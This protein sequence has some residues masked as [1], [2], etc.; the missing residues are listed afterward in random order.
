MIGEYNMF[1]EYIYDTPLEI[2]ADQWLEML[3]NDEI[4][5]AQDR[6][7]IYAVLQYDGQPHATPIAKAIGLKGRGAINLQVDRLGKR[8][9]KHL[10]EI[11]FPKQEDGNDR[12]W[13]IPYLG[14]WQPDKSRF[15][16]TLRPALKEAAEIYFA[17]E[18]KE[19]K[20]QPSERLYSKIEKQLFASSYIDISYQRYLNFK[21]NEL[22][23]ESY[24][25]EILSRLNELLKG[26]EI[27]DRTV[28]DIVKK[29]QKENPSAGSFVHWSNTSDLVKYA[30]AKP[31]EV[32]ILLS[33]LYNSEALISDRIEKFREKAKAFNPDISLGAP[34]FG[35]LLAAKDYK[36]YPIYK[37]EVFTK[38]KKDY[39][40]ELKLGSV[41]QNYEVYCF[42][43]NVVLECFKQKDNFLTILDIQDFF[44]CSTTYDH[45]MVES[46]VDYLY[47]LAGILGNFE[48]DQEQMLEAIADMDPEILEQ[49]SDQY[50]NNEKIN[51][52]RHKLIEKILENGS[53]KISDLNA[54]KEEVRVK[55]DTNILNSWSDFSIL[56]QLYYF[57]KKKKVQ[58]ELNKIHRA[59]RQF[60]EL[61]DRK[62][63]VD[64]VLNGF[65]WNNQF[66]TSRCW[67]A[68]YETEYPTHRPAP[69]LFVAVDPKGIEY[70]L[71]FGDQHPQGG[72]RSVTHVENSQLFSY[73]DFHQKIIEVMGE[74]DS[75]RLVLEPS[76]T[77]IKE[78]SK[79][80]WQELIANDTVFYESDLVYL[81]KMYEMGGQ[82]T[83][84]QLAEELG[85]SRSAFNAPVVSLVKRI[86]L[87][88]GI[89]DVLRDDGSVCYWCVLFEGEY[90][91]ND[92]F[93]WR[94]KPNLKE[95]LAENYEDPTSIKYEAYSKEDF[96]SEVF[97]DENTYDKI[98]SLL[99]YK[100]N[101]ILQGPP[102][103]GKTFVSKR[104]AYSLMEAKDES[105]VE[106]VQFH[107][108][109]SYEDFVMGFRPKED[110]FSLQYGVFYDFCQRAL[111]HPE[112]DY[113]FIIDEI[114]RG[115][116]SKIFGELFML[117]ERDKRDEFVTMGYSKEKFTVPANL[118]LI[119]TMNTADRSLAQLEVALRRRFAFVALN[120]AFNEKWRQQLIN[121]NVS[122]EMVSKIH[123]TIERL[124]QE[125]VKDYQLGN[126]YAIGHSFFSAKPEYLDEKSWFDGIMEFEI[127]PLLEEYYFDRPEVV[128]QLLEEM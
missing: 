26:Q 113:Y 12:T 6:N 20:E 14:E 80:N 100:K 21:E 38:I 98:A 48:K 61:K 121:T 10:P 92:H 123:Q 86:Q 28:L 25:E 68:V 97:I 11:S 93:L 90:E 1:N 47:E 81:Y 105:R 85:K 4:F 112:E 30:E 64:K 99:T 114:N 82:A 95:A 9:M 3:H 52:I 34:L 70:G 29:L 83:A 125:I 53:V 108:N 33:N 87:E 120:P 94:L 104:L 62:F 128:E 91:E 84:T 37:Q 69:Q 96:L 110:G 24:K 76:E 71:H 127:L 13:H 36:K 56:F 39:D 111:H 109:Y 44:Y 42:I 116:L 63:V 35:Y 118:H 17:Q 45:I 65:S 75:D 101:I 103:V 40:I 5:K 58:E 115:N 79:E 19:G 49:L 89:E 51:M 117:I 43:C 119:G 2:T 23:D 73:K 124:N 107:Q 78:L 16:W 46:A 41:G 74:F 55:Y 15:V 8:I 88:T 57:D 18:L 72:R 106:M 27:N 66:G 32:A 7:M 102:G 60:E 31:E 22:Y 77:Y 67:L 122:G 50:R 54:I 59:I 126:G